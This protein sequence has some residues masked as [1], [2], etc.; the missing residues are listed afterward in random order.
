MKFKEYKDEILYDVLI[1]YKID[2]IRAIKHDG[3]IVSRNGKE[4]FNIPEFEGE[5][6]E[7]FLGTFKDTV[8]AVKT[9]DN[10]GMIDKSHVYPLY[11]SIDERL[12]I[13][14]FSMVDRYK[15]ERLFKRAEELGYEGLVIKKGDIHYKVKSKVTYDVSIVGIIGGTG[16]YVNKLGAFIVL[17]DGVTFKVGTGFTDRERHDFY[18]DEYIGKCIEIEGME[19]LPSGRIRHPRFIRLRLDK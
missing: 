17:L 12:I 18:S 9:K 11:P 3:K 7:I 4:L 8:S 5:Q 1:S 13:D 19:K 6:A 14:W 10:K 16:K 2:G 15:I